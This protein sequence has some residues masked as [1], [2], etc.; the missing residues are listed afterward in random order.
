M[1]PSCLDT[2]WLLS[3]LFDASLLITL[4]AGNGGSFLLFNASVVVQKF[5]SLSLR[6]RKANF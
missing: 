3:T 4:A 6:G 2:E 1:F 5:A